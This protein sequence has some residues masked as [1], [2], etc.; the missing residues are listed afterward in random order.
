[1]KHSLL[2]ILSFVI[3]TLTLN[4]QSMKIMTYNVENLFDTQHDS[5]KNDKEYLP[6]SDLRWTNNRFYE[7]L[8]EVMQV[9]I[10]LGDEELPLLVGLCEV[11]NDFVLKAMTQFDPYNQ[12]GYDYIHYE[13][14]DV[15]GI[16]VALLYQKDKFTPL[17]SRPI[18]VYLPNGQQGRDLLYTCGTLTDSTLLHIIQVHFP[19]RREGALASEPNREAAAKAVRQVVDSV[20]AL[21]PQAAIIIMGDF[22]DNPSDKVPTTTLAALPYTNNSFENTKLYNLCWDGY[23][24]ED[25]DIGSYFHDGQW[26]M[27]DQI[28][29][30]GS[31]LNGNISVRAMP[32]AEVYHPKWISKRDKRTGEMIPKR[33]YVGTF[34][35]GGVSDH[36]PIFM[37]L[38][39]KNEL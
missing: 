9:I 19:S 39:F 26:D 37:E 32:K 27:L 33:T 6:N 31:L 20:Q 22:N 28:I 38:F 10:G 18:P 15:R 12:L 36:F 23:K 7:K 25:K 29:I 13:G 21:D 17:A 34:Y 8:H 16:D 1:M 11:E 2:L 5:L 24:Y 30:S 4:S 3:Q 14:P 35:L